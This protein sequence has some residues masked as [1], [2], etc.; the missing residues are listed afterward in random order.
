LAAFA[1]SFVI[2]PFWVL[3]PRGGTRGHTLDCP[4]DCAC[5]RELRAEACQRDDPLFAF[6][7]VLQPHERVTEVEI[8]TPKRIA[9]FVMFTGP[10][11][12]DE[13]VPPPVITVDEEVLRGLLKKDKYAW[14]A[15]IY[16]CEE[17]AQSVE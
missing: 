7:F 1:A 16:I 3:R 5:W 13:D 4:P 12:Y 14:S 8:E 9:R 2:A 17:H 11:L 15:L 10:S 6:P